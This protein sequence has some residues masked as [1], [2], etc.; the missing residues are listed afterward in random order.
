MSKA[1]LTIYK[2]SISR[3]GKESEMMIP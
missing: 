2:V 3:G 1:N